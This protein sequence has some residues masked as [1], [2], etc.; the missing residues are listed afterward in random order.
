MPEPLTKGVVSGGQT[1]HYEAEKCGCV[2]IVSGGDFIGDKDSR[3]SSK[4]CGEHEHRKGE[5]HRRIKGG[6]GYR[7]FGRKS[8]RN[9]REGQRRKSNRRIE[10]GLSR[11]TTGERRQG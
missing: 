11:R 10:G 5:A 4:R 3:K 8:S 2:Y 6:D 7:V 1:M 9:D